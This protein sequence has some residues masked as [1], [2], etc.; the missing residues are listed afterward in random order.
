MD[1]TALVFATPV[2]V[3]EEEQKRMF[4][5]QPAS[6]VNQ[7]CIDR[8][9]RHLSLDLLRRSKATFSTPD[10]HAVVIC[11]ASRTHIEGGS[12]EYWFAFHAQQ[13]RNLSSAGIAYVA[14]GCGSPATVLL[15]PFEDFKAWLDGLNMTKLRDR[16]Y[17]H[18]HIFRDADRFILRRRAGLDRIDLTRYLLPHP[19]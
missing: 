18:V 16:E 17:W 14:Y 15:I 6:A 12:E 3:L 19:A 4:R 1:G 9:K 11:S 13:M 2:Q 7:D 10:G 5:R 8:I